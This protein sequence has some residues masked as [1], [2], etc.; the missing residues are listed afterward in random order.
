MHEDFN[1]HE[2]RLPQRPP[3][4]QQARSPYVSPLLD[5]EAPAAEQEDTGED[6][7]A[8]RKPS[9][10]VSFLSPLLFLLALSYLAP[11]AIEQVQYA[12]TRG[13]Q[14][15]EYDLAGDGLRH[16]SLQEISQAYQMVSQR[17]GPSVVHISVSG[18]SRETLKD[19]QSR[20]FGSN[21]Y[22]SRGQGSGVVVDAKGFILT[23][24]HVI[25]GSDRI[26]V[27]L[28]N[29]RVL[30]AEVVG[31]DSLTDLALLKVDATNLVPIEWAN[32]NDLKVGSL[33]WALGS[34][35][36]LERS[37]TFGI[38]S[39]KHRSAK[40]GS[41]Y[42]DFLQTDAAV[43]PGNSGG[44]LVDERGHLVG[45]NTA[46]VGETYQGISFAVPSN[47]ARSVYQRLRNTGRVIRGWLGVVLR[48]LTAEEATKLELPMGAG[49]LITQFAPG[50]SPAFD[51]G[52]KRYDV[53]LQWNG[54][55]V[56]GMASLIRLIG[57]TTAN[58]KVP[59]IVIR[60]QKQVAISVQVGERPQ[61]F[62]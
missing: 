57:Q 45:I 62:E 7:D 30:E 8:V 24:R 11:Y 36:G 5:S 25:F 51:A 19:E 38:L 2:P 14:R 56:R 35:F 16:S 41:H 33:V 61:Q 40:I 43:N 9:Y 27:R 42:Q 31:V 49:A 22:P 44:P 20:F 13:K 37:V 29:R 1:W 32:S 10:L 15:A 21:P 52:M 23:N 34:P 6:S 60:R 28:E 26:Q 59:V 47:V 55:D 12:L 39:A 53:I 58:S 46:I 54:Q 50:D 4:R 18:T 17:V 3:P 48:D